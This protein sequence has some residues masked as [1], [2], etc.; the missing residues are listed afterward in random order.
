[1][2]DNYAHLLIYGRN[3]P[4]M[5]KELAKIRANK[6]P[7]D[8][9]K[10]TVVTYQGHNHM[11]KLQGDTYYEWDY[12]NNILVEPICKIHETDAIR[13]ASGFDF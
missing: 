1:M 6:K 4:K 7:W 11:T 3:S 12:I 8:D 5:E 9:I 10:P 2:D 13:G